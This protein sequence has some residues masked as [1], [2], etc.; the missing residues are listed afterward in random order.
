[1]VFEICNA[2]FSIYELVGEDT[3]VGYHSHPRLKPGEKKILVAINVIEDGEMAR[4]LLDKVAGEIEKMGRGK[5]Y[6]DLY[7]H[8]EEAQPLMHPT[9]SRSSVGGGKYLGLVAIVGEEGLDVEGV[10][11]V[12]SEKMGK[13]E[14]VEVDVWQEE[15]D[16]GERGEK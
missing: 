11:R 6:A 1:M 14:G 12:V 9:M 3:T 8:K 7:E 13:K 4:E 5:V 16:E 10:R 15:V 2:L